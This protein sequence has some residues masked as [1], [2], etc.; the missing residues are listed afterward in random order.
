NS[1]QTALHRATSQGFRAVAQTLL[2]N[3]ADV[4]A[5]DDDENTPL[6]LAATRGH[7]AVAELLL[8]HRAKINAQEKNGF[9][10]LTLAVRSKNLEMAEF[11]IAKKDD[12]NVRADES[13]NLKNGTA[14]HAGIV[15]SSACM[16]ELLLKNGADVEL[17]V[18]VSP[19]TSE[20]VN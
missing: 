11:L 14:L 9:T 7:K 3:K 15:A 13:S 8:A 6:H 10:P 1:G 12:V 18:S 5:K 16:V 17:K 19:Y 2:E 4:N 20:T